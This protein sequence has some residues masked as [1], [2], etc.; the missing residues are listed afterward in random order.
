MNIR[1]IGLGDVGHEVVVAC[2]QYF[3]TKQIVNLLESK[4]V[5]KLTTKEYTETLNNLRGTTNNAEAATCGVSC[6]S[7][8]ALRSLRRALAYLFFGGPD[9]EFDQRSHEM[10]E[11]DAPDLNIS[12][13]G[14]PYIEF[15]QG[16]YAN[17]A[18]VP[19]LRNTFRTH[20]NTGIF[21]HQAFLRAQEPLLGKDWLI[22]PDL[23]V[24]EAG[25]KS[26]FSSIGREMMR[27]I[28]KSKY[29]KR[30]RL[31]KGLG[32][33]SAE[34]P[35][36]VVAIAF[37]VGDSFGGS[38]A[39]ELAHGMREILQELNHNRIVALIGLAV[40]ERNVDVLDG[41]Y[42]G[43]YLRINRES[44]GFDGLI[45]RSRVPDAIQGFG[46][47]LATIAMASDPRVIQIDNPDAN[48]LQRD[49]GKSLVSCGHGHSATSGDGPGQP[50]LL[51]LYNHAKADLFKHHANQTP[52]D[53]LKVF[54]DMVKEIRQAVPTW[55]PPRWVERLLA[56]PNQLGNIECETARKVVAYVGYDDNMSGN[57]INQLREALARDF[58]RARTVLYKYRV[59]DVVMWAGKPLALPAAPVSPA[60]GS[61]DE[62]SGK[63][64]A[65]GK[66]SPGSAA[67][68]VSST[69]GK[70]ASASRPTPPVVPGL[71]LMLA[72]S[73]LQPHV[74][75]F[76]VDSLET[77]ALERF[78][79]YVLNH[80]T[81]RHR[82]GRSLSWHGGDALLIKTIILRLLARSLL[83]IPAAGKE[84]SPPFA[85]T[86]RS[87]YL[88]CPR[89]TIL[90]EVSEE[91]LR[92]LRAAVEEV[93][94]GETLEASALQSE[95]A[96]V[97]ETVN[98]EQMPLLRK[99]RLHRLE[100]K[101]VAEVL[102][103]LNWLC[104]EELEKR[105]V[106]CSL[107]EAINQ[108]TSKTIDSY[109]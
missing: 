12:A 17:L 51:T 88:S 3:Q 25:L 18:K 29:N 56:N 74:A 65:T 61:P 36:D 30:E 45:A 100:A 103:G 10:L 32:L 5:V 83:S 85:D 40:Y 75:L 14:R 98:T 99:S 38:G 87:R 82:D 89:D 22:T 52:F 86:A 78:C 79:D 27:R 1:L 55:K 57:Q 108:E 107:W 109:Y 71:P 2:T 84:W 54:Q 47:I 90:G 58:P 106:T 92:L 7:P 41:R 43:D 23:P 62:Q 9:D 24:E 67:T 60:P 34:V 64:A 94:V 26:R 97:Y 81:V 49:F 91:F 63:P 33:V 101:D 48:Q 19:G 53:M 16:L 6:S 31:T 37:S 35:V 59:G 95:V 50:Q 76:V 8:E 72:P 80:I 21:A 105:K 13:A 93:V 28:L 69:A 44:N 39:D 77:V 102:G 46:P 66:P 70:G 73:G 42:V 4:K 104:N 68:E 96:K 15:L 20:L 11:A